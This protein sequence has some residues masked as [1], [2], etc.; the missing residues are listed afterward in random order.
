MVDKVCA[1]EC[2]YGHD[3]VVLQYFW[4]WSSFS[5]KAHWNERS[6]WKVTRLMYVLN[7]ST[8]FSL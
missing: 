6:T 4:Q 7:Y 5:F 2:N 1:Y 3:G 8:I